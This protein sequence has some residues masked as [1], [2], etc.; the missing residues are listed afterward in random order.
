[1][2]RSIVAVVLLA[3]LAT[4]AVAQPT[5][6]S[7]MTAEQRASA[8]QLFRAGETAFKAN[9]FE[10]A[11]RL[12]E[13]AYA[14]LP[15]PA[16]AFSAA[17]S[18]RLQYAIDKD[19]RRLKR[20]VAL[21]D[22]YVVDDPKGSRVGDAARHL[23]E[24]R[25]VLAEQE[26]T[27]GAAIADMPATTAAT[28]IMVTTTA[29]VP[30]ARVSV[31]GGAPEPLPLMREVKPGRHQIA[32][33]AAGYQRFVELREAVAGDT[34]VIE[35]IL[36]PM[37]AVLSLRTDDGAQVSV[38]GR[39]AGVTPLVRPLELTVG[40]HLI[41]VTRRGHR[42][43][44][45]EVTVERGEKL[46]LDAPLQH[47]GQRKA[48]YVVMGAA[49]AVAISAGVAYSL[50]LKAGGEASDLN[51]KRESE[52]LSADERNEYVDLVDKRDARLDT[53]Y[54]LLGVAGAV[55]VSGALLYYM[56]NPTAEADATAAS[57]TLAPVAGADSLGLALGGRF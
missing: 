13:Q 51:D 32:I 8:E 44:S 53:T 23:S 50:S 39:P 27:G 11:A 26:R 47:T 54:I 22:R 31:D 49:A 24:L 37:P 12:F 1:M 5:P 9:Q 42:P 29:D 36:V 35:A 46:V 33:T 48:S 10:N 38:D 28:M 34:R 55:A 40:K 18:Y 7:Q 43:W 3:A 25:P 4:P 45:R 6:G 15:L 14:V 57:L 17:Q 2:R 20:A 52:G 21:Y 41:T 56:D 16:I 30:G 19:P